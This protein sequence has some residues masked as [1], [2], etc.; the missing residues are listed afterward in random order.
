MRVR[1]HSSD[2][3]VATVDE[4]GTILGRAPGEATITA[5]AG[6]ANS[7]ATLRVVDNPASRLEVTA[8]TSARTGD[9]VRFAAG[10]LDARGTAVA[11]PPVR[12]S[13]SGGDAVV[14]STMSR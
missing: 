8:A 7:A 13:V 2:E 1:Y 11:D 5:K 3:R 4:C 10:A 9:V 12:W 6:A 14:F